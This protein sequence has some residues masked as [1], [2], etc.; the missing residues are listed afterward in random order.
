M[1]L[2]HI[3][4]L[5]VFV[6]ALSSFVIGG[7]WY[8]PIMFARAWMQENGFTDEEMK[9]ANMA[10]TFGGSFVLALV[11]AFNLAAFLGPEANLA[12]GITAGALAGIGWV[13]A[14]L[15]IIYLFERKSLKLFLINAGYQAF[16][17][18]VMG[19]ILGVWK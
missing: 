7:A 16:T 4:Y 11:I 19:G 14:A 9:N 12:W 15:G 18:I 2:S 5:A 6:A 1:D 13:A 3:N 8:S 10:K 17:F